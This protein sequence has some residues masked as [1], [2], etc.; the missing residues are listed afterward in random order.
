MQFRLFEFYFKLL[1]RTQTRLH[2]TSFE[3]RNLGTQISREKPLL[4]KH[5]QAHARTGEGK[6]RR[7]FAD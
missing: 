6:R 7:E 3:G 2:G 1:C 5:V 4:K